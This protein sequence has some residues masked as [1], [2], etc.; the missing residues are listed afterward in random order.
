M[1]ENK[2]DR[3][4][5]QFLQSLPVGIERPQRYYE[6]FS[7]GTTKAGA[8]EI[9]TLVLNGTKTSTGSL[10][11]VYDV[12]GKPLPKPGDLSIVMDGNGHPVCV[13]ETTDVQVMPFDAVDEQFAY[14]GGEED[15][16]L[17]SWRRMYWSYI[18]TECVRIKREPTEKMPLVCERFRV[19]YKEPLKSV[20]VETCFC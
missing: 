18:V 6:A 2:I 19:V 4:W 3:Y 1:T 8:T 20:V 9:A 17:A 10:Q 11:W 5:S 13:I 14:E 16:T 7:F 12:E 15:R